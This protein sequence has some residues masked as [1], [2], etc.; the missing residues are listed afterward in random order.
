M[1]VCFFQSSCA[2]TEEEVNKKNFTFRV[3]AYKD[4]K[5][6]SSRNSYSSW[7]YLIRDHNQRVL[8]FREKIKKAPKSKSIFLWQNS[9]AGFVCL[10]VFLCRKSPTEL[11]Y[12]FLNKRAFNNLQQQNAEIKKYW[13]HPSLHHITILTKKKEDI[14][15]VFITL[16][17]MYLLR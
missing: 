15:A 17:K 3:K 12:V 4:I 9:A 5:E 8:V 7:T 2:L 11:I 1:F 10:V 14:V 16:S 6:L 13:Q